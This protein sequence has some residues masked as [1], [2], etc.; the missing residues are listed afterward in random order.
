MF[1]PSDVVAM[2]AVDV[3]KR[4]ADTPDKLWKFLF[5]LI[6]A[7]IAIMGL[8]MLGFWVWVTSSKAIPFT[9]A[10]GYVVASLLAL[11]VG[12]VGLFMVYL[13]KS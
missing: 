4:V 12:A 3:E 9:E 6:F 13:W 2:P 7:V 10:M 1:P 5:M 8:Q 11:I